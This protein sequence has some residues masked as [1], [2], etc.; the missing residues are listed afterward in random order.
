MIDVPVAGYFKAWHIST[1]TAASPVTWTPSLTAG[2]DVT[3]VSTQ[4]GYSTAGLQVAVSINGISGADFEYSLDAG[5]GWIP[6]G[7]AVQFTTAAGGLSDIRI[8]TATDAT[9]AALTVIE[10]RRV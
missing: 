1:A 4:S 6:G 7:G 9:A 2:G 10:K 5:T 3:A 8:R